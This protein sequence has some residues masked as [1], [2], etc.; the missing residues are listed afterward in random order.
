[1][2]SEFDRGVHSI[3]T[4]DAYND[5]NLVLVSGLNV[6]IAPPAGDMEAFPQTM[7]LPWAAFVQLSDGSQRV[8][9]QDALVTLL[10]KQSTDNQ[11]AMNIERGF[12]AL[13][14][15]NEKRILFHNTRDNKLDEVRTV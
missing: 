2:Q 14:G 5:R 11:D 4:S 13:Y 6:D 10:H 9:E 1:M 8:I 3:V 12:E 7:F 15:Q